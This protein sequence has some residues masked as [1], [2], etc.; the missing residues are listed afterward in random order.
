MIDR[1]NFIGA[2]E[3]A[4][5]FGEHP[6]ESRYSLWAKKTGMIPDGWDEE[7]T[8]R[9]KIGIDFEKAI[10]D[11]WAKREGFQYEHN[12]EF[13]TSALVEAIGATPDGIIKQKLD[14]GWQRPIPV[15]AKTVQPYQ[16]KAWLDGIPRNYWWQL[17][18]QMLVLD[19]APFGWLVA[20]FGVDEIAAT[21]VQCDTEAW[22]D[23]Q[24]ESAIFWKQARGELP[25]PSTD[26][27]DITTRALLSQRRDERVVVFDDVCAALD[28]ELRGL[29]KES[30]WINNQIKAL[31]NKLLSKLGTANRGVFADGSGYRVVEVSKK[32]YMVKAS[33]SRKLE[34]F[35]S[36][37]T[38]G[39]E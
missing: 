3:V 1:K 36:D 7:K 15:D 32:E 28:E 12:R 31:K 8:E 26:D 23:I 13:V 35:T 2:S 18:Q 39:E 30:K 17:Q 24:R 29:K 9:Q 27:S 10:L 20:M 22:V 19:R 37:E 5:L 16:R 4:A 6:Y 34:R 25:P 11:V 21:Q 33:T 38:E 14:G